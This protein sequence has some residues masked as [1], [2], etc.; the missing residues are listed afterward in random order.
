MSLAKRKLLLIALLCVCLAAIVALCA[1]Q[2]GSDPEEYVNGQGNDVRVLLDSLKDGVRDFRLKSGSPMPEPGATGSGVSAPVA[3]GFIFRGY[4]EGVKN[5]DGT[6]TYGDKWDFSR[7]VTSSMTLYAKWDIKYKIRINYV[8]NGVVGDLYSDME[9][10]DNADRV[11]TI[12]EPTW[13]NYT[14]LN[15]YSDVECKN[16]LKPSVSDPYF[17]GCTQE[18]PVANVYATFIEGT[19]SLVY[20]ASD[21]RTINAGSRFYLMNDI[22]FS[23]LNDSETGLTEITIKRGTF[24]GAIEGNGHTISNLHYYINGEMSSSSPGATNFGLFSRISNVSVTNVTFK[25]CSVGGVINRK[26]ND[27]YTYGFFAGL[28]TGTNT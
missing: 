10:D 17:H 2:D 6:V 1:C 5:D 12:K 18:N 9:I 8:T 25:D 11:S 13:N 19:W 21:M 23:E 14:F 7:K 15:L 22:D 24:T 27:E 4:Y 16:V 28:A 26:T 20:G 3:S